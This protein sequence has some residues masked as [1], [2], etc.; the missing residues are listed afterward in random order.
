MF[1]NFNSKACF[2]GNKTGLEQTD[3][4]DSNSGQ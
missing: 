3:R 1:S 4:F 2:R